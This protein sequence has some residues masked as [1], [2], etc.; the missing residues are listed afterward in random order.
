MCPKSSNQMLCENVIAKN[1]PGQGKKS[2]IF[3]IK[4]YNWKLDSC[5]NFKNL[6]SQVRNK[7]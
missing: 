6:K 7:L 2:Q 3:F 4:I 5:Y 1:L